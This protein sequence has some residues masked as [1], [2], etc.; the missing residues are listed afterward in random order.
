M[1]PNDPADRRESAHSTPRVHDMR[2]TYSVVNTLGA[3]LL[4]VDA[5]CMAMLADSVLRWEGTSRAKQLDTA[6]TVIQLVALVGKI[7]H[8]SGDIFM[9]CEGS[10]E[11]VKPKVFQSCHGKLEGFL[12]VARLHR[13][14]NGRDHRMKA[15]PKRTIDQRI[16]PVET[17]H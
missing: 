6:V 16:P 3:C 14:P 10:A 13:P 15:T 1:P 17:C 12:G 9:V 8:S 11:T 2:G 5:S 4:F 7:L